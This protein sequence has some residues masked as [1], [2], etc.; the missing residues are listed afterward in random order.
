MRESILHWLK[1]HEDEI[2]IFL[3]TAALLFLVRSS[4]MILNNYAET[5]F[6][7]RYG[8][9]YMPIVNMINTV[10]TFLITGV[11]ATFMAKISGAR[12]LF[13]LFVFCGLSTTAIRLV[14]PMGVELVY[15]L[16]FML[17]SQYE[18]LQALLFWNLANDLFNTRQSKRI[19]PL[20]SAGGVLGL[21]VGSFGTPYLARAFQFD[22]LLLVY[23]VTTLVGAVVVFG[24]GRQFP[25]LM[26]NGKEEKSK[27]QRPS[28][29]EEVQRVWPLLKQSSLF[30]IVLVLTFMP[31]V[32]I[33]IMN[34]Q[35]NFS[36]DQYFPTE[37][38]MITFFSYFR[39]VL[40]IIS[41]IILLFVGRLYGYF[42]VPLALMLH[43]VNYVVAFLAFFFRFDIFSAVYARMS[44]NILRTTI[45][46]PATSILIGLFPESYRAMVRPFLRG[47]VVRAGLLL[48]SGLILLSVNLFHPRYL[49]LVALPFVLGWVAAPIILKRNYASI[50]KDLISKNM[51]DIKSLEEENPGRLFR[52]DSAGEEIIQTFLTARGD[53]A[54]WYARLLKSLNVEDLDAL[55]LEVLDKQDEATRAQLTEML[56]DDPKM[57]TLKRLTGLLDEN[58]PR[59]NVSILKTIKKGNPASL[60]VSKIHSFM[61]DNDPE[62]RGY[63]AA[64]IY[65][66]KPSE[67]G[68]RIDKWLNSPDAD[69][70]KSGIV[71]AGETSEKRYAGKLETMILEK[72][73]ESAIPEILHAL[74][75]LDSR[76]LN[77]LSSDLLDH[78]QPDIRRAALSVMDIT[79]EQALKQIIFHLGD[80]DE[81]IRESVKQKIKEADYVSGQVM[82]ESLATPN[83]HLRENVFEL[84]ETLEIKDLDLYRFTS[85]ALH[86][87]YLCLAK[88]EA[89]GNFPETKSRRLL[90]DHLFEKKDLILENLFRILA[91]H[92]HDGRMRTVRRGIFSR[93]TRVQGNSIELL[94]D[95]MDRKLFAMFQPLIEG[96]SLYRSVASGKKF[97]RIPKFDFRDLHLVPALLNS[98]DWI[99]TSLCLAI[100]QEMAEAGERDAIRRHKDIIAGLTDSPDFYVRRAALKLYGD[101]DDIDTGEPIMDNQLTISDKILLLRSI[102]I[103]SGLNVSE[104]GAIATVTEESDYPEGETV[105]QEGEPGEEVFLIIAGEVAVYKKGERDKEIRLDI[106]EK[107]D[108]FGEMALFEEMERSATIRTTKPSRFLILH[109]QEFDELVR[110]YPRIA[111]QICTELSHRLRNLQ[112]RLTQAES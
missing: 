77:A 100:L 45:N 8:I 71:A 79:G 95:I 107:G 32:V 106:M 5:T 2:V 30:K 38:G 104:L 97:F 27:R 16:L 70:R 35:F 67:T 72:E 29:A 24:M 9:E 76:K 64:C 41:L 89:L 112:S 92:D 82:I 69:E 85:E 22:N 53:D 49:S 84:L 101:I 31:N 86:Q 48:G 81:T 75:K 13:Y 26:R 94:G 1:L 28:M 93:D 42:G 65:P 110:E 11:M 111:L 23:L 60:D 47:T 57:E 33:P 56:S 88:A 25:A 109:K 19:F 34:Y 90:S 50:L 83:R 68:A 21:I 46:M 10:A 66:K 36:V 73:N 4:G 59:L 102:S 39:G 55:I 18:L 74:A 15:P 40:N 58:R 52:K 61:A 20:L 43:P 37:S 12:I 54:I 7:K 96:F 108:Y 98:T 91:I 3:W 62:V 80:P 6:L 51:L 17:K 105:I 44:T 103:F 63:A 99:E 14:I 87:C 78:H